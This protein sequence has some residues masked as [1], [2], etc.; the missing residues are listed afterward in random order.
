MDDDNEVYTEFF[1]QDPNRTW[2]FKSSLKYAEIVQLY[3]E[4]QDD[5]TEISNKCFKGDALAIEIRRKNEIDKTVGDGYI[6]RRLYVW[7]QHIERDGSGDYKPL[8]PRPRQPIRQRTVVSPPSQEK[9]TFPI[10]GT[11]ATSFPDEYSH[12]FTMEPEQFYIGSEV[13]T[14]ETTTDVVNARFYNVDFTEEVL[15]KLSSMEYITIEHSPDNLKKFI[16]AFPF[17]DSKLKALQLAYFGITDKYEQK[18]LT[19]LQQCQH[20]QVLVIYEVGITDEFAIKLWEQLPQLRQLELH[21][22]QGQKSIVY[23]KDDEEE[24]CSFVP[25]HFSLLS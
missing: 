12:T 11:R 10:L 5:E 22:G 19:K 7:L 18:L 17:S 9:A 4:L 14:L 23:F 1:K 24:V 3:Y 16:K 2:N 6:S 8:L 20:L 21:S 13:E 25:T 15:T